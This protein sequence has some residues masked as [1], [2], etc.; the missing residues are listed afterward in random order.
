MFIFIKLVVHHLIHSVL[1]HLIM[2]N[3]LSMYLIYLFVSKILII[4]RDLILQYIDN[5]KT[6]PGTV[7]PLCIYSL[8][9]L[10]NHAL[11]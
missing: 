11:R 7:Q 9:P 1:G 6:I 2:V 4:L 5:N 8:C 3:E 10:H